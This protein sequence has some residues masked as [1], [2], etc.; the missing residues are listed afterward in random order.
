ME[1]G[2]LPELPPKQHRQPHE[3]SQRGK[4]LLSMA[5]AA[6][7]IEAV[8]EVNRADE[9]GRT[10]LYNACG[11]GQVDAARL[12]AGQ[13]RGRQ[14]G[15]CY[16][17]TPLYIAC[18][19]GQVE[20]ARLLLDNGA[21]VDRAKEN[22]DA[23][24]HPA[25]GHVDAARLLLDK[26]ADVNRAEKDYGATP[27]HMASPRGPRRNGAAVANQWALFVEEVDRGTNVT[28][29]K[30]RTSGTEWTRCTPPASAPRPLP[31][32]GGGQPGEE[33]RSAVRRCLLD[34]GWRSEHHREDRPI[35]RGSRKA[36]R[37]IGRTRKGKRRCS[38]RR[39]LRR[40]MPKATD[41][42]TLTWGESS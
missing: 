24:A 1:P 14:S 37:S 31:E 4:N 40:C 8:D 23:A 30:P 25:K 36:R 17:A 29:T 21:E 35:R 5:A 33:R 16:G 27:L 34:N 15:G 32:T 22:G 28:H 2:S 11:N 41:A 18:Q 38:H 12:L 3:G 7:N 19:E 6:G 39:R 13:R 20:A 10:P 42:A 26:G 9:H